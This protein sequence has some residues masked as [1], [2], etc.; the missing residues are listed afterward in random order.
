[1][2]R[3]ARRRR[4]RA[5]PV[6][7]TRLQIRPSVTRPW[8]GRLNVS[9]ASVKGSPRR[10]GACGDDAAPRD[11]RG[12][13]APRPPAS[14]TAR[15]APARSCG[16]RRPWPLS[17]PGSS[18]AA[19]SGPGNV[20]VEREVLF[21]H[22][23]AARDRGERDVDAERVVGVADRQAERRAIVSIARRCTAS[24]APGTASRSAAASRAPAAPRRPAALAIRGL[25]VGA[26][27]SARR[28]ASGRRR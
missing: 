16:C 27:A 14:S 15:R 18:D 1:M 2:A 22:G 24:A 26:A 5:Q 10:I 6:R 25:E 3:S 8:P 4:S 21:D 28:R 20:A 13:A 23:R 7:P 9:A 12:C 11:R 17:S 19:W